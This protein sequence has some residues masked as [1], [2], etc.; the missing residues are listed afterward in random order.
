LLWLRAECH[1]RA[2]A[3]L[4]AEEGASRVE[5][6]LAAATDDAGQAAAGAAAARAQQERDAR[7]KRRYLQEAH[8]LYE[9]AIA[10]Y[11]VAGGNTGGGAEQRLD[12]TYERLA[13][14]Y[15]ADCLFDLGEYAAA[16]ELYD[17]AAFRYQ[18]D[19]SALSAYV[20]IVNSYVAMGQPSD[21]R[22]AN[23]RAKW[24]LRRMPPEKFRDGSLTLDREQWQ[25]WL[26]WSGE[27]G[28]F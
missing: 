24:L 25:A 3:D 10:A 27:S 16:I 11:A 5:A 26:E 4:L 7:H 13:W 9:A 12:E 19:P 2:A 1:R 21:A 18:D 14:F 17:Q 23:E 15:R 8:R 22:T 6:Q 20:Q 28:L